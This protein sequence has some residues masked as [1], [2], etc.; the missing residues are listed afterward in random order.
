MVSTKPR[1][2]YPQERPSTH[3]KGAG[4]ALGLVWMV[5]EN[6][7]PPGFNPWIIQPVVSR[8]T[9]Y[10]IQQVPSAN[11]RQEHWLHWFKCIVVYLSHSR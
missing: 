10:S 5:I 9:N 1:P 11:F 3:C 8:Y 2:L 4:W 6:R 7:P